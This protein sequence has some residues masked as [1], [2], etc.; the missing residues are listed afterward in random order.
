[1]LNLGFGDGLQGSVNWWYLLLVI[2]KTNKAQ[3]QL[4][5]LESYVRKQRQRNYLVSSFW[6]CSHCVRVSANPKMV[7]YCNLT[8][9]SAQFLESI[10]LHISWICFRSQYLISGYS[11]EIPNHWQFLHEPKS[12]NLQ[13]LFKTPVL[14]MLYSI[15]LKQANSQK[16]K[17]RLNYFMCS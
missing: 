6:N 2:F 17:L 9:P 1:M 13:I 14:H 5:Y 3:R 11:W 4:F 12:S 7:N 8:L 16:M 10:L 15:Y